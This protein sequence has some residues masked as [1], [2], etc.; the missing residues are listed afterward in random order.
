MVKDRLGL[1]RVAF[2]LHVHTPASHDWRGDAIAPSDL[3]EQALSVGLD[4]LAITD[5]ATGGWID[6]VKEAADGRGLVVFPG[7]ELNNLAGNEGIHLVALFD[8]HF[9]SSDID[10]FLTTIGAVTGAGANL[11]RGSATRGPLEV[12]DEIQRFGG[13]A[14]L[15]HCRSSRGALGG[16]RGDL[17][18]RLVQH[19]SLLAVEAPAEDYFDQDRAKAGKRVYDVLDGS[20]PTYQRQLAVYQASDN[21]SGMGHGHGLSGVGSRFTYFWVEEPVSLEGLRQCFI[22]R[23]ARIGMPT[24]GSSVGDDP[25]ALAPGITRL[26][27]VGGF[28]DDLDVEFHGGLTTILGAKGSGKSVVIELLRFALDQ[29]PTQAEIRRDHDTKLDKQLGLYGRVTVDIRAPDGSTHT[30][31]REY[32]PAAGNPSRGSPIP[33]ADLLSCH[34]LSQGE[35][36]RIAESEDEQIR[37][38]DSF[39]DFRTHQRRIDEIRGQLR[40][41]DT[42]V[43]KQIRS[44]RKRDELRT[45]QVALRAEISKTDAG[46][47][48]PVFSK[49]Q[50]AQAKTQAIDREIASI[51]GIA[52]SV[53]RA[54]GALEAVPSAG[55]PPEELRSDPVVRRLQSLSTTA[56][57]EALRR[58]TESVDAVHELLRRAKAEELDWLAAY[59]SINDEYSREV[60]KAGGDV[61]ALSQSR[62]R[63]VA[64]LNALESELSSAQQLADL[65]QP[66]VQ[67]RNE[68]LNELRE[69]Q[70]AYTQARQE[71]CDWFAAKS[72][73]QIRANV[74][75]GSNSRDFHERLSAM[76]KGSYLSAGEVEAITAGVSPDALVNALL[77]YHLTNKPKTSSLSRPPAVSGGSGS[78]HSRTSC[79][80]R[81]SSM[82]TKR[83]LSC[84]TQ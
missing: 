23:D 30:V 13:F 84:S 42:D 14:V 64:Q 39:F 80:A 18:T 6:D 47:K 68:L 52:D 53:M 19:P 75:Q 20:D 35:I 56:R 59:E 8:T 12:L 55:E 76:K 29:E 51:S 83:C 36:V 21:P 49:F 60:Q 38:I 73:G 34:F 7:V 32:N 31:E 41:L 74:S 26:R 71:R 44:R 46:L 5:H 11:E 37:F 57:G 82:D 27:V 67:R 28:L 25:V 9:T 22:D 1:H 58:L 81:L 10:R 54:R 77:R 33:A 16:M 40:D 78:S 65:L 3:V 63:L 50:Q 15:A 69:E 43:A 48:S 79:S 72:N 70:D 61:R 62:A 17:R 4:G 2:D 45:K 66:T 24:A